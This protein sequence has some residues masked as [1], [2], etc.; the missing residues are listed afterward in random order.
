MLGSFITDIDISQAFPD[1]LS[2]V[3]KTDSLGVNYTTILFVVGFAVALL[4][5]VFIL[6]RLKRLVS[7]SFTFLEILPTDSTLKSPLATD[8]LFTL[9]HSLNKRN[10]AL[11]RL[12]GIKRNISFELVSTKQKGIRYVVRVLSKEAESIKKILMAYLPGIAIKEIDDSIASLDKLDQIKIKELKLKN[13]FVFPLQ[14][15]STLN[16]FDPIAYITG[17]MTKLDENEMICLQF[18]TSPVYE[19]THPFISGHIKTLREML[20]ENKDIKQ[21]LVFGIPNYLITMFDLVARTLLLIILTP[22]TLLDWFL[23]KQ[24]HAQMLAWWVFNDFKTKRLNEIGTVKKD[25]YQNIQSKIDQPLFETTIRFI[26][27]TQNN[28]QRLNGLTS[29]FDS[30]STPYQSFLVKDSPLIIFQNR[31]FNQLLHWY[32]R[33]RLTI[34]IYK[35]ILSV[36]ELSSLYHFPFTITT[37]TEDLIKN[38]SPQLPPPLSLKQL[39][40]KFDISFAYNS[41]G[42]TKTVIGQT[43]EERRRH[44]YMIGATGTGKTTLLMQMIYKDLENNKGLAVIDPHGDLTSRILEIIPQNRIKDV[45]YFNPYDIEYPIGLNFLELPKPQSPIERER[46]KEF[47]T[48]SLISVFHK[49]YDARYSGP[50]MEHILR[51]V[52]LTA[53]E[54]EDPTLFTIYKLLTDTKYRKRIIEGLQDEVLKTFWKNEFNASGSYQRAEQISPITNKLG[55]FLTTTLTRNILNQPKT[56]LDFSNIMDTG[57]ILLCDL[58]KGKIGEDNSY[59]LG[60]LIIAKLELAAFRRINVPQNQRNDFFLY[61]DE[62]Q[63][64]ATTTFAQVLSE[65]RKYRLC[66]IL[67]HQNTVQL[68][69][70]LLD[71][72]IGNSGTMISFRTGSPKDEQKIQPIFAPQVEEGQIGNLPSYHF[73]IKINALQPQDTFTGEIEDFTMKGNESIKHEVIEHSRKAYGTKTE[74][75]KETVLIKEKPKKIK[76]TQNRFEIAR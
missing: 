71:T 53:L 67:A 12:L 32:L 55:R 13:G 20:L 63:N 10:T 2:W 15:Q 1:Y 21:R 24:N 43:L 30:F 65:A 5:V 39:D 75:K 22:F 11:N 42:Q 14:N 73:Y 31:V 36:K 19:Y 33:N 34:L 68:E 6:L 41:Y 9:I 61:V 35:S 40:N 62:F 60:S 74:V 17:H 49:L 66:A 56:K 51:N 46:E 54:L 38:K 18:I 69:A 23:D 26:S 16:Q 7:E 72:I 47:I 58:S 27:Q 28:N 44:T 4:F 70:D 76:A 3:F 37:Q 59:F 29:S 50:R 8:E 57:K 25:L 64:F 45:V 52:I 48:S